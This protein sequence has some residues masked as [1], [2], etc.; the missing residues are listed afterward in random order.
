[1]N[2]IRQLQQTGLALALGGMFAISAQAQE[3]VL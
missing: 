1:M 3:V 2:I